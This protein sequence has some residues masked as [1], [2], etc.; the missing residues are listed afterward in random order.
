MA[1]DVEQSAAVDYGN[2]ESTFYNG[3]YKL[4]RF[5]SL[6]SIVA[7]HE[8]AFRH[9]PVLKDKATEGRLIT[10]ESEGLTQRTARKDDAGH[11]IRDP[12]KCT[13]DSFQGGNSEPAPVR[14]AVALPHEPNGY[15][16][17]LDGGPLFNAEPPRCPGGADFSLHRNLSADSPSFQV[18]PPRRRFLRSA[19]G[20]DHT[21]RTFHFGPF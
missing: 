11:Y 6:R 21:H 10:T 5:W 12:L 4:S 7:F 2:D 20:G 17:R 19:D 13:G 1:A 18:I 9:R 16:L 3:A 15:R 14:G 8:T